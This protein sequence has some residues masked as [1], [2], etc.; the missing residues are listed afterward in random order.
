MGGAPGR[1]VGQAR[2]WSRLSGV[3]ASSDGPRPLLDLRLEDEGEFKGCRRFFFL[4]HL[5]DWLEP[6]EAAFL[7]HQELRKT[8]IH[9][10]VTE[11]GNQ[12]S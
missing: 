3:R 8:F 11:T 7:I 2:C 9:L 6:P 12:A 4:L 1:G 5:S 10:R